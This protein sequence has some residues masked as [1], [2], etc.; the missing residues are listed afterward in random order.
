MV[1][2]ALLSA[3]DGEDHNKHRDYDRDDT[4]G[5]QAPLH[6]QLLRL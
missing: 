4:Y 6:D 3:T 5:D 2:A 1:V